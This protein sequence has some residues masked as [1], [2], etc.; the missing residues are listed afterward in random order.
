MQSKEINNIGIAGAGGIGAYLAHFLYDYGVNRNQYPFTDWKIDIYDDD[1]VDVS[2]LLH[3]NYTEDDL[4]QPKA[5]IVGTKYA[6]NPMLRFMSKADFKNYDVIFSCVDSMTFRKDLYEYGWK[7]PNLYWID[8]RCS[9]RN[10]GLYNSMVPRKQL[11]S[12]LTNSKERKGCLLQ[13]DK[14]N[15]VSHAT[16]V[17]IAG[18]M[19]QTFLNHIRGEDITEKVL[20][21]L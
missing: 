14:E 10:I 20:L 7:N 2:N 17:V 19:L 8:G 1:V 6:M 21:M 12:D 18:M 9:S 4:G 15:K 13:V 5:K 11:E 3:Q 16:P